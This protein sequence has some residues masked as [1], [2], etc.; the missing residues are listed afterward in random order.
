LAGV[1]HGHPVRFCA[2]RIL[3]QRGLLGFSGA[4]GKTSLVKRLRDEPFDPA[5]VRAG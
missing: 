1:A 4:V 2:I 5:Q 3:I